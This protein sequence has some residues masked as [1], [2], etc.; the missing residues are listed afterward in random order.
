MSK[1]LFLLLLILSINC[2]EESKNKTLNN[3][4]KKIV[5][6][7]K[8]FNITI[9]EIDTMMV[10]SIIMEQKIKKYT[11][12]IEKLQ[13]KL[14]VSTT[15]LVTNKIS[16]DI[17]EQCNKLIKIE[18]VNYFIKN[19]TFINDFIWEKNFDKITEINFDKYNNI[20]DLEYTTNQQVLMYNF[21]KAEEVFKQKQMEDRERYIKANQRIKIGSLDLENIPQG[22]KLGIFLIIF[23]I[24]F[25]GIFYY[26]KGLNK[27]LGSNS[28]KK[29]KKTQ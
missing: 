15:E 2:N 24:F 8:P 20:T 25:G 14:N 9:D 6:S 29:K 17:F 18:K 12:K 26:L 19:L 16:A 4:T 23:L 10:C 28:K 21:Q 1:F 13:K 7:K 27:K 22:F 5:D 3:N 11:S